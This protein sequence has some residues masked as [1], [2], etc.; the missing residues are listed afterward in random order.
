[1]QSYPRP[2][3]LRVYVDKQDVAGPAPNAAPGAAPLPR[4]SEGG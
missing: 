3:T 1:M 4:D 2:E